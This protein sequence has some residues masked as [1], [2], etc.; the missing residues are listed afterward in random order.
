MLDG[1]TFFE[2]LLEDD[3]LQPILLILEKDYDDAINTIGELDERVFCSDDDSVL[4]TGSLSGGAI[5]ISSRK[6]YLVMIQI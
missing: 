4:G 1:L 6:V 2:G 5:N 3:S